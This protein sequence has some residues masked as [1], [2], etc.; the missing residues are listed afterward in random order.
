MKTMEGFNKEAWGP[1]VKKEIG[2][3]EFISYFSDQYRTSEELSRGSDGIKGIT[4]MD[5][6]DR[7]LLG[8]RNIDL[9]APKMTEKQER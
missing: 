5:L 6:M 1:C 9:N 3:E 2:L 7:M 4:K 8:I